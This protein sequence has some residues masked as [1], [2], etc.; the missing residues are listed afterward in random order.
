MYICIKE[1]YLIVV[2]EIKNILQ[3]TNVHEFDVQT[4]QMLI[5]PVF[6]I[7]KGNIIIIIT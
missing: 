4:S 5:N 3:K 7:F 1:N 6:N 2:Y